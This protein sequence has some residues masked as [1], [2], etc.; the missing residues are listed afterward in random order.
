MNTQQQVLWQ[1]LQEKSL[2][3]GEFQPTEKVESPWFIKLLLALS[4]WF[5]SIFIFGFLLLTLNDLIDSSV[6]CLVIGS[7]L[8]LLAYQILKKVPHEFLE[9]LMLACSLAGQAL[10]AWAIFMAAN[11]SSNLL[12]WFIIFVMQSVLSLI[13]PHY[14]HRVCSAFFASIALVVTLHYLHLSA[15]TSAS[16]LLIVLFL[17]LNEWRSVKWQPAFEAISYGV[18]LLLITLKG[19]YVVGYELSYWFDEITVAQP[20]R[21]YLDELLLLLAM[22]YLILTLLKRSQYHFPLR[23]K[24]VIIA[25]TI[26]LCLLSMQASGIT[27]GF[28]L[29]VLGFSNSNKI[30]Q[31][32]GLTSLIFYISSYYYLL[33]LSLL[34][35]AGIL[36][37]MGLFILTVRFA[38]LKW[39]NPIQLNS[40]QINS[41]GRAPEQGGND[42]V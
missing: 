22:L 3:N 23:T 36:L 14:V 20:W 8:I 17:V 32:L 13:M 31:G 41:I 24:L 26:G 2:V 18:I 15:F 37:M 30:L 40:I 28:A 25:A 1:Q 42:A 29:L 4:G 35:K 12:P 34:E 38:L 16:L 11:P 10:I 19:S 21:H 33:T 6:A 27:I 39:L 5:S 9:H 7:G